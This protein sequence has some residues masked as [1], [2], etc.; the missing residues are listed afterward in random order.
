MEWFKESQQ[1]NYSNPHENLIKFEAAPI[2][3]SSPIDNPG[4]E[5]GNASEKHTC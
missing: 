3:S 5:T 1:N 2:N 4:T